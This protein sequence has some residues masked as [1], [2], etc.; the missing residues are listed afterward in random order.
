MQ[1]GGN[2][3]EFEGAAG[4]LAVAAEA[5]QVLRF[6]L[7]ETE[8]AN[9]RFEHLNGRVAVASSLEPEVVVGADAREQ[10]DLLASQAGHSTVRSGREAH[11]GR[12]DHRRRARRYSPRRFAGFSSSML[13]TLPTCSGSREVPSLP[14][15]RGPSC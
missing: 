2:L 5:K 14:G 10:R 15:S 1:A 9:Q 11:L 12:R 7:V 3:L 8:D 13:P 4:S 6:H